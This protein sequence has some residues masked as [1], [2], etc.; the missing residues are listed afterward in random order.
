MDDKFPDY[1][2]TIPLDEYIRVQA[3]IKELE[4]ALN[5]ACNLINYSVSGQAVPIS[6]WLYYMAEWRKTLGDA[7]REEDARSGTNE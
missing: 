6:D 4:D 7:Y 5:I 2:K 1:G 3:R